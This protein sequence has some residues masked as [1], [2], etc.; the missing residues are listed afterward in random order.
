MIFWEFDSPVWTADI[1][2]ALQTHSL[3]RQTAASLDVVDRARKAHGPF[4]SR[5][6][7]ERVRTRII[8]GNM[9]ISGGSSDA[10]TS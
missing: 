7:E 5:V 10:N 6:L 4:L 9:I 8:D 1:Q 3:I 2:E